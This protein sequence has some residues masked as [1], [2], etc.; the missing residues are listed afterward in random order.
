MNEIFVKIF[1][2]IIFY[3]LTTL[4]NSDE[5]NPYELL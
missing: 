2:F 4:N 5:I 3:K 1:K